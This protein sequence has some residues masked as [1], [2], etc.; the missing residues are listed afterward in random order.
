MK[1]VLFI[2]TGY[3]SRGKKSLKQFTKKAT[4]LWKLKESGLYK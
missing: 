2:L 4:L 1:I 3:I